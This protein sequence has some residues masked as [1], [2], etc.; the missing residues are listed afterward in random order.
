M[1][2]SSV[3]GEMAAQPSDPHLRAIRKRAARWWWALAA[4]VI[5]IAL[6]F[7]TAW[8][9]EAFSAPL[10]ELTDASAKVK[11]VPYLPPVVL[12]PTREQP[13]PTPAAID[14]GPEATAFELA[15]PLEEAGAAVRT[16]SSTRGVLDIRARAGTEIS[17]DGK[18]VGTAPTA[19]VRLKAGT[20]TVSVFGV[21]NRRR[22]SVQVHIEAGQSQRITLDP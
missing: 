14:A 1:A 22:K 7:L 20:H 10:E 9:L 2:P 8:R 3:I 6:G 12:N 5:A 13:V 16:G 15:V 17:I 11:P 19:A 21:K 4:L 18:V